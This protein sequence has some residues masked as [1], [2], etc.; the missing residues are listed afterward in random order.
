MQRLLLPP[1]VWFASVGAMV[2]LQRI[3]PL[4][5]LP[6]DA[7]VLAWMAGGVLVL[8]GLAIAQWHARLFKRIGTNINTF[9]EPGTLTTAGL[10]AYTRNPMYLGMLLALAGVALALG[11]L[12]PWLLVL[13]FCARAVLV[14]PAG[15]AQAGGLFREPVC[16]VLSG[17]AALGVVAAGLGPAAK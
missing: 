13:H 9:G 4:A 12:S 5:T 7:C 2:I 6:P 10:F 11:A 14:H 16:G 17:C 8:A 3:W 1:V 15:G